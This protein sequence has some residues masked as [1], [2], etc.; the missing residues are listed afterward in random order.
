MKQDIKSLL[1]PKVLLVISVSYTLFITIAFLIPITNQV[2]K[3]AFPFADKSIHLI[4]NAGLFVVWSWYVISKTVK[5]LKT[6]T[7]V[8][9]FVCTF[10]YGILIE[11]IQGRYLA[12]RGA[13]IFDVVANMF[14][15]FLGLFVVNVSKKFIS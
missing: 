1:G 8:V 10:F 4:L 3:L 15:L 6:R 9:L 11:V 13:D 7:L 12:T 5:I 2:P 14:G